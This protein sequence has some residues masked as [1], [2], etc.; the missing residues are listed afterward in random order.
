MMNYMAT[1]DEGIELLSRHNSPQM[2]LAVFLG[3]NPYQVALGLR[4]A[5]GG[6]V[7]WSVMA[8]SRDSHPPLK[9][10]VGNATHILAGGGP[11]LRDANGDGESCKQAYGAEWN[12]LHL[13]VVEATKNFTLF[14]VPNAQVN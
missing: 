12:A 13:K 7:S 11:D 4:P 10:M 1:V 8:I 2:R 5:E 14:E 9:R 3:S 6:I